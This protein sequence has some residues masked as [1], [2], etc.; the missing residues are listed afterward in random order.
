MT[1]EEMREKKREYGFTN[2]QISDYTGVPLATVQKIFAGV[3]ES[4]RYA[5][6][7][8]L[9]TL[10]RQLE[11]ERNPGLAAD[12]VAESP[13]YMAD[14]LKSQGEYTLAD[15]YSLPDERR[16]E[17][18][19]GV[20]YDMSSPESIHQILITAIWKDLFNFIS[21]KKGDCLPMIA[22][23]DVQLDRDDRTMV[24]PDVLVVCDRGKVV[25]RCVY[26][27]DPFQIYMGKGHVCKAWKI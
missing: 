14:Y 9:E 15:Y 16:V 19:D 11:G 17:L 22:P 25:R 4:P 1:L 26:G 21:D 2:E 8:A 5:T 7:Q 12:R 23:L 24:Q 10:F 3:T 20:I 13:A 27:G 18:I 6:L